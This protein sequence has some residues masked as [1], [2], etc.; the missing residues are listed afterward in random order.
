MSDENKAVRIFGA[1]APPVLL[2][3]SETCSTARRLLERG[4]VDSENHQSKYSKG[5]I[6]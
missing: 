5:V 2:F 6:T 3:E 4:Y 1:F